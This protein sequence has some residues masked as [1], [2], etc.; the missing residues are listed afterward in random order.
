METTLIY[1]KDGKKYAILESS[2]NLSKSRL[3]GDES[4][5]PEWRKTADFRTETEFARAT[6]PRKPASG[7]GTGYT[8]YAQ[9]EGNEQLF[10]RDLP[11]NLQLG[12]TWWLIGYCVDRAELSFDAPKDKT[13][14]DRLGLKCSRGATKHIRFPNPEYPGLDTL[15]RVF[16]DPFTGGINSKPWF[17]F[18]SDG[19]GGI[20]QIV[21][22]DAFKGDFEAGRSAQ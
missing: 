17:D 12:K 7:W 6:A 4:D 13:D 11:L 5:W 14:A 8:E 16:F 9:Y 1:A 18:L 22:P 15:L 10:R 2:G 20:R 21:P 19:N 3:A